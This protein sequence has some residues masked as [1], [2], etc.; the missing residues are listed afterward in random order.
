MGL[1]GRETLLICS[2]KSTL[3]YLARCQLLDQYLLQ[4]DV[5]KLNGTFENYYDC[6]FY[7]R[8]YSD[9]KKK[10]KSDLKKKI[11]LIHN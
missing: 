2:T 8:E 3:I 9:S 4:D 6:K 10:K 5:M 7:I 11:V 1:V